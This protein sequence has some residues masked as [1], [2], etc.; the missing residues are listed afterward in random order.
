MRK[1]TKNASVT[2]PAPKTTAINTSR[3]KPVMRDSNVIALTEA[4]A[5]SRF[6]ELDLP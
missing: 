6:I 1:A 5:P 2:A 4:A 3:T